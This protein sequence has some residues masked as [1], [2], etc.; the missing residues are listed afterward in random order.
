MLTDEVGGNGEA[1]K[2]GTRYE[3]EDA[4][5]LHWLKRGKAEVATDDE[6]SDDTGGGAPKL[7][8]GLTVPQIKDA[9]A[10]RRVAIPDGMTL[11]ADLAELLDNSTDPGPLPSEGL[12]VD[13]LRDALAAKQIEIPE[14]TTL[15]ADL[16]ALLDAAE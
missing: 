13:Q 10:A 1:L 8:D 7:S 9:L 11:K 14:G 6:G 16:A 12:T 5:A 4:S 3:L 15:K 2:A